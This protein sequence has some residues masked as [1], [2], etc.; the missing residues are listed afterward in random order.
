[1]PRPSLPAQAQ[2]CRHPSYLPLHIYI[3]LAEVLFHSRCSKISRQ[4][5]FRPSTVQI[6]IARKGRW[7]Q[8]Q[9]TQ[10]AAAVDL[11]TLHHTPLKE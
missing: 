1:M 3:I 9:I 5:A 4:M 6:L 7:R 2:R 11:Q 8:A 10:A